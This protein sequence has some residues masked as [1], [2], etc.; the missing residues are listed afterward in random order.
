M[1]STE[2]SKTVAIA[3]GN[4][5]MQKQLIVKIQ[6]GDLNKNNAAIQEITLL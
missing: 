1:L 3:I 2:Q 6:I 5:K 4:T